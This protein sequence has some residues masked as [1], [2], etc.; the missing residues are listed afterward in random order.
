MHADEVVVDKDLVHRL[1]RAQLPHL[2]A[3]A[4][5]IVEPWGTDNA[6]W[7]LGT[8]LVVHLPR[9]HWAARQVAFEATWLPCLA[10]RL[11]ISVPEPVA[12]GEPG[13]G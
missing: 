1:L 13:E 4:L 8:D 5:S 10:P 6:I 9:I 12:T 3:Q 7:R 11:P 2:A